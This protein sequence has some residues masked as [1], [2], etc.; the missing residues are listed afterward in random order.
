[1]TTSVPT[2][3]PLTGP[4]PV[5]SLPGGVAMITLEHPDKP[6]VIMDRSLLHRLDRTLDELENDLKAVY[7][8]SA[9][10]KVFV[11]GAD[12]KEIDA[13][14][15]EALLTYLASGVQTLDRIASLPCPTVALVNGAALGGGLELALH[16]SAIVATRTNAKGKPYPIGLPEAG[17][18]LCPGWGGTQRLAGRIDPATAI[19]ATAEGRPFTSDDLPEGLVDAFANSVDDLVSTADAWRQAQ[20]DTWPS[21]TILDA[22]PETMKTALMSTRDSVGDDAAAMAVCEAIW[23]G[24]EHGMDTGLATERRLLVALRKTEAT[25][26]KLNA[27]FQGVR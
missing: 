2:S 9:D 5:T 11:A 26:A 6:L 8:R 14:D 19:T 1:M 17:L 27:F 15:D 4:L 22:D 21:R 12:L 7:I 13:L 20:G 25:R 23:A 3:Q 10:T 16:C 24:L 18:G